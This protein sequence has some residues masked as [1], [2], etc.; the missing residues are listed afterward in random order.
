MTTDSKIVCRHKMFGNRLLLRATS[1]DGGLVLRAWEYGLNRL[2]PIY[3]VRDH[4]PHGM[5]L[6]AWERLYG[7]FTDYPSGPT[8]RGTPVE[9][10]E[11][12]HWEQRLRR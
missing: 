9:G 12:V 11:S 2:E 1:P 3:N 4:H 7:R 8:D 6:S 5:K 10:P